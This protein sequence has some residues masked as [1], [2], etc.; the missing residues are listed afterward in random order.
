[1]DVEGYEEKILSV[2]KK[3]KTIQQVIIETH[4][5]ELTDSISS[6]LQ[7]W[8]FNVKDVSRIKRTKVVKNIIYHPFCFF[9]LEKINGYNTIKQSLRYIARRG[10]SPVAADN[11]DSDQRIL[12]GFMPWIQEWS[13]NCQE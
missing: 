3:Y 11:K 5:K 6:I 8:G 9:K 10:S 2:F 13:W 1:M 7:S 4:S 12:Y